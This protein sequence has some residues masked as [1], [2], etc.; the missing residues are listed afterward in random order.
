MFW[1]HITYLRF[2][3]YFQVIDFTYIGIPE[4]ST[5]LW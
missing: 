2:A 3:E 1:F 5:Y 4:E